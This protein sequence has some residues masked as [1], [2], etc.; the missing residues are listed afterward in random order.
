LATEKIVALFFFGNI[1]KLNDC[2]TLPAYKVIGLGNF[3]LNSLKKLN[4][5]SNK[6]I[7]YGSQAKPKLWQMAVSWV[8]SIFGKQ[9]TN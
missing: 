1:A 6:S 4:P 5:N 9:S 2:Q 7:Q 3:F 8:S